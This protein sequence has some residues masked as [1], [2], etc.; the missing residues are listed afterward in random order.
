[1]VGKYLI[2]ADAL[3]ALTDERDSGY[4]WARRVL[5]NLKEVKLSL[6]HI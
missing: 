6:I 5:A 3:V 4:E 2:D 1:M